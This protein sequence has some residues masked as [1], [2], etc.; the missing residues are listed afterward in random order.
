MRTWVGAF[1]VVALYAG[2]CAAQTSGG[3]GFAKQWMPWVLDQKEVAGYLQSLKRCQA[4]DA[5]HCKVI[6]LMLPS[7]TTAQVPTTS[8]YGCLSF[9][10]GDGSFATR[11]F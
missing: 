8:G 10:I 9:P 5:R 1:A 4:G 7:T 6:D 3:I 11:C 2:T